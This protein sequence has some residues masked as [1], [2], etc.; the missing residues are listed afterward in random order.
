MTTFGS[1]YIENAIAN[2]FRGTAFPTVP[3]QMYLAAFTAAPTS[4]GG[5]TEVSG[6]GYA[7]VQVTPN[8]TNWNAPTN[9]GNAQQITNAV[10][11]AFAQATAS[12]GSVVG[13]ALFDALTGGNMLWYGDLNSPVT[14]N[15]G[16]QL[17]LPVGN[18][19][20]TFD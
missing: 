5:G 19:T 3:A 2:W 14:V 16:F 17:T 20:I 4:S 12:W 6:G 9:S 18:I 7:R 10:Q 15:N 8:T 1:Q 11:I 13:V